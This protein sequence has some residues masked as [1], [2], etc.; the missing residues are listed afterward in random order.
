MNTEAATADTTHP[1]VS[2]V[3]A[4]R[5]RAARLSACLDAL[6][7]Q[8]KPPHE[9]ILVDDASTDNTPDIIPHLTAR[10]AN[11]RVQYLRND[12]PRGANPS[13]NRG[14]RTATGS[15]I[16]FLDDDCVPHS[17]WLEELTPPFADADVAATTGLVEDPPPRN[18]FELTFKGTHRLARPGSAHRLVAGNMCIRRHLL[19]RFPLHEDLG[20]PRAGC[21]E[22][23]LFLMLQA[24]GYRQCVVPGAVVLHDHPMNARSFFAQAWY[25]GRAAARFVYKYALRPRLDLLPFLLAYGHAPLGLG[26]LRLLIVPAFFFLAALAALVFNDLVRKG[27]SLGET[28]L[29]FPIL[30]LYYHIRLAGYVFDTLRMWLSPNE[31]QRV[32]LRDIQRVRK[33][34]T[35]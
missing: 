5:N 34:P 14:I 1:S 20:Y 2:V 10:H 3:I 27:K 19:L 35:D 13:R 22:E 8:S 7:L 25:G 32:D 9:A 15:L 6:A 23:G 31:V 16:A 4:T 17:D 21:D 33:S 24:A 29:T 28:A 12:S 30:L 18:I 26:D 11:L